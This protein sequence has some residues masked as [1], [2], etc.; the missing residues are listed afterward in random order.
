[1]KKQTVDEWLNDVSYDYLNSNKYVPSTFA[2][3]FLNFINLVNGVQGESNKTPPMHLKMLDRIVDRECNQV[4]NLIFRGAAKTTLF[5]EYLPLYLAVFGDLPGLGIVDVMLYIADSVDNG[6]KSLR[7]NL[8]HRYRNST[9][10]QELL[11]EKYAKFTDA[12]IE[13][14]NRDNKVFALKLF[15]ATSGIRGV[16]VFG[17]RP[18]LVLIDDVMSDEAAKSQATLNL[19]KDTIYN[20]VIN[21]VDPT[22]H[23]IIFNGT[24]FN[25]NDVIVEAVESG[26]WDVSVYPVCEEFPCEEKDFKGAWEDRFTYSFIKDRYNLA[27]NTGKKASFYQELM[28]RISPE[29]ERIVLDDDIKWFSLKT[30]NKNSG[31]YNFYITTDFATS[32]KNSA[33]FSV[34]LVW[35]YNAHGD[36]FLLDGVCKQQLMNENIDCLFKF[37]SAY[38][39]QSVG[40]EVTG[41]QGG[42]I[43]WIREKMMDRN[44]WFTFASYNNGNREGIRPATDKLTRF[45][46]IVPWFKSGKIFFPKELKSKD[47]MQELLHELEFVTINGIKSKHDDALD[48]VS[49]LGCLSPWKPSDNAPVE[50]DAENDIWYTEPTDNIKDARSSYIV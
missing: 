1:M 30:F 20:G 16:K 34:I 23:L 21:A 13:F 18:Q 4:V 50:R 19:I 28:L 33:D 7:K 47:F 15:G 49:M 43:P 36:W 14:T 40:L 2:L 11:P 32:N 22:R 44:I 8:E 25:K 5:G 42:F 12:Y 35:A 9:F 48:C 26:A 6:A 39:P 38:N 29:E 17:K 24:P 45:N 3:N 41:Q 37:V 27:I 10:L 46:V 31:Y